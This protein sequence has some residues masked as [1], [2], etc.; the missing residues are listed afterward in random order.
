MSHFEHVIRLQELDQQIE[1]A[2]REMRDILKQI[3]VEKIES[4]NDIHDVKLRARY[5][6]LQL[7]IKDL[8]V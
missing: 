8:S 2:E 3:N 7:K 1:D 4:L 5:D 6:R